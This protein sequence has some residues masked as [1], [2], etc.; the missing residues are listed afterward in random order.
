MP[1]KLRW[2]RELSFGLVAE[3]GAPPTVVTP[4]EVRG[5]PPCAL[6]H[7]LHTLTQPCVPLQVREISV[8]AWDLTHTDQGSEGAEVSGYKGT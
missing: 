5:I 6:S 3:R 4:R 2:P 8:V 7:P 1:T